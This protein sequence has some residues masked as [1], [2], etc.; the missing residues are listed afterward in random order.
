LSSPRRQM[1]PAW[2]NRCPLG[3]MHQTRRRWTSCRLTSCLNS[4]QQR[5]N[6][7]PPPLSSCQQCSSRRQELRR[8]R[9][10]PRRQTR[11][12]RG[13]SLRTWSPR[14]LSHW[15]PRCRLL[16]WTSRRRLWQATLRLCH[17]MHQHR[18][19]KCCHRSSCCLRQCRHHRVRRRLCQR[20][21][22]RRRC[23]THRRRRPSPQHVSPK[24]YDQ[25]ALW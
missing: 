7:H 2:V 23:S 22:R 19:L 4:R 13:P 20:T 12:R 24:H 6:R 5:S 18:H 21:R 3:P 17:P 8:R 1:R 10:Q 25:A 9:Q 15:T 11:R 16:R 14:R